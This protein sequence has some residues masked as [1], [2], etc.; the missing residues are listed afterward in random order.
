MS[1]AGGKK[2]LT[3][4]LEGEKCL[5]VNG[6]V[7]PQEA[8]RGKVSATYDQALAA[9]RFLRETAGDADA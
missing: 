7:V 9:V 4:Y 1:F 8:V 3:V 6:I 2:R 5:S